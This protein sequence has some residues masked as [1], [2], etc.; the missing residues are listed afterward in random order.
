MFKKLFEKF[1][2]QDKTKESESFVIFENIFQY[3]ENQGE[4]LRYGSRIKF[5]EIKRL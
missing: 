2:N 4:W 1:T 5:T 3:V